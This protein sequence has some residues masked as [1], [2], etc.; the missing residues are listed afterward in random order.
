MDTKELTLVTK[1]IDNFSGLEHIGNGKN[2]DIE[3][4]FQ[5][6]MTWIEWNNV[7]QVINNYKDIQMNLQ[8]VTS[9]DFL[10]WLLH[11]GDVYDNFLRHCLH[12]DPLTNYEMEARQ[13]FKLRQLH[14]KFS[15]TV[16]LATQIKSKRFLSD[17]DLGNLIPILAEIPNNH[18]LPTD[19]RL[20]SDLG[21]QLYKSIYSL[22]NFAVQRVAEKCF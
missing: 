13:L 12:H 14:P 10:I 9:Q 4:Y 15:F 18:D 7:L 8:Y 19:K 1:E 11:Y 21:E 16:A 17:N 2:K 22:S 20:T 5:S 6:F 3:R